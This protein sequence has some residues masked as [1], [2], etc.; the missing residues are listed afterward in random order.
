MAEPKKQRK[1]PFGR[2]SK[3]ADTLIK[4]REYLDGGFVSEGHLIPSHSGMSLYCKVGRQT[5]YDYAKQN[6]DFSGM[7]AECNK[8]QE[9]M[10]LAGG[11][12]GS[13]NAT[14][15]KL[16]LA[17]HGYSDRHEVDTTSSDG[18]MTPPAPVV[19]QL[20]APSFAEDDEEY[21]GD[22]HSAH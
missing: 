21:D 16:V 15:A 22:E 2:P 11:L 17:K 7:L 1:E 13:Y 20:V 14:I 19:I 3:L 9:A 18:S 8:R 12:G 4:A 6:A 10:L 5:L